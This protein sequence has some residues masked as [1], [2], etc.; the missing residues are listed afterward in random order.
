L[1][2]T[3]IACYLEGLNY[4]TSKTVNIMT[5]TVNI[6]ITTAIILLVIGAFAWKYG[7]RIKQYFQAKKDMNKKA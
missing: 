6:I 3:L 1:N 7:S 2:I 5:P 4:P